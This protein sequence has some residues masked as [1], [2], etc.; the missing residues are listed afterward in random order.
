MNDPA[1]NLFAEA[2]ALISGARR[3]D[4]GAVEKS[5]KRIAQ[6][7]SAVLGVDVTPQQVCLCMIGLKVCREANGHKHD[8]LVD[9]CG[10]TGLLAQLEAVK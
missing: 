9:I 10:Y 6:A 2:Q 5:F 8:S 4:Y 3:D 7:W 1:L